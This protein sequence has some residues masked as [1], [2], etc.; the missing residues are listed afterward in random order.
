M[1]QRR[2][3]PSSITRFHTR[4]YAL[5]VFIIRVRGSLQTIVNVF[6]DVLRTLAYCV[7][8]WRASQCGQ[9]HD[10]EHKPHRASHY[11]HLSLPYTTRRSIR[12]ALLPARILTDTSPLRTTAEIGRRS[13]LP[14][15]LKSARR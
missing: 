5:S 8:C 3:A 10:A 11:R 9:R 12:R 2:L 7:S 4:S 13:T 1:P 6:T 15:R 14:P